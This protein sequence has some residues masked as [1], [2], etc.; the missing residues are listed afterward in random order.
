LRFEREIAV[1]LLGA[2]KGARGRRNSR[3]PYI[4][5]TAVMKQYVPHVFLKHGVP[6][7]ITEEKHLSLKSGKKFAICWILN[8]H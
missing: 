8:Q 4:L 5:K 7:N 6:F 3:A 1:L 2:E